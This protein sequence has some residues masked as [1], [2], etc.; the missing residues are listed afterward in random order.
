MRD[1]FA[2]EEPSHSYAPPPGEQ[3]ASGRIP[4]RGR[5]A[6]IAAATAVGVLVLGGGAWLI[7]S[8]TRPQPVLPVVTAPAPPVAPVAEPMPPQRVRVRVL[9]NPPGAEVVLEAAGGA[10]EERGRT[11]FSMLVPR[12][13]A[14][15]RVTVRL[16]GYKP[17]E[18]EVMP[19][20]DVSVQLT[21]Q[22]EVAPRPVVVEAAPPAPKHTTP[23]KT[24][25]PKPAPTPKPAAKNL[26]AGDLA[27]P[28][29]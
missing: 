6:R 2:A 8:R 7:G 18:D 15:R 5:S 13:T 16:S 9:S 14:G 4:R 12:G 25:P 22:P 26:K 23:K 3:H 21:L 20:S 19:D 10:H 27:D 1:L 24:P 11:P 28:F 17:A 29:K